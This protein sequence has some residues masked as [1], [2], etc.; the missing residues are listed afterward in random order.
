M[1]WQTNLVYVFLAL[2]TF[3]LKWTLAVCLSLKPL[4]F[5]V[6][7]HLSLST[8]AHINLAF[9]AAHLLNLIK[10]QEVWWRESSS[11]LVHL[12]ELIRYLNRLLTLGWSAENC[13]AVFERTVIS[14]YLLAY[15]PPTAATLECWWV[16]VLGVEN[17]PLLTPMMKM[18]ENAWKRLTHSCHD[19]N[20]THS[21]PPVSR[22]KPH[23]MTLFPQHSR[24][25]SS[26]SLSIKIVCICLFQECSISLP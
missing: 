15:L 8:S 18:P 2:F 6:F 11:G 24:D 3:V 23:R 16:A 20:S 12:S 13:S 9:F 25:G 5:F 1:Y 19:T 21:G 7:L 4:I 17:Q 22:A 14:T 26:E 10:L